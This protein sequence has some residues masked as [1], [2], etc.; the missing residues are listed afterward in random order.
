MPAVDI[1]FVH[2]KDAADFTQDRGASGLNTVRR[3]DG[4]N[5]VRF[6]GFF[7]NQALLIATSELPDSRD[8]RAVGGELKQM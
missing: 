4:I 7:I 6:D 3:Q 5:V 8:V 2:V 1:N